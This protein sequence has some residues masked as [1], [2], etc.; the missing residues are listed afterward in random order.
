[1]LKKAALHTQIFH[2]FNIMRTESIQTSLRWLTAMTKEISRRIREKFKDITF[3]ET[4]QST[5]LP[6]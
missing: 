6:F 2:G 3:K 1:M 4:I 5:L